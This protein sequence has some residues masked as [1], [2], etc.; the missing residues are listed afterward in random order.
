[1]LVR[2]AQQSDLEAYARLVAAF[3]RRLEPGMSF[4]R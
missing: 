2:A 1:M 4:L 3:A